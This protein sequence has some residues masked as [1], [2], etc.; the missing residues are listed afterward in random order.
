MIFEVKS[1]TNASWIKMPGRPIRK[2]FCMWAAIGMLRRIML[3]RRIEITL[4]VIMEIISDAITGSLKVL[5]V[6]FMI[7]AYVISSIVIGK[8]EIA[9]GIPDKA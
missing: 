3:T 6:K 1:G 5:A 8:S 4:P 9:G 7:I 2:T